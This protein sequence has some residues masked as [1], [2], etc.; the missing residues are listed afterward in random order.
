MK[1][2][3]SFPEGETKMSNMSEDQVVASVKEKY[4]VE[5][6]GFLE[7]HLPGLVRD[8]IQLHLE[9]NFDQEQKSQIEDAI[10]NTKAFDE[11]IDRKQLIDSI[12]NITGINRAFLDKLGERMDNEL[13]RLAEEVISEAENHIDNDI[14][15]GR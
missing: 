13:E 9:N 3:T 4:L 1:F 10:D 2:T 12:G 15:P 11:A 6:Q 5:V 7:D 14:A 8:Q